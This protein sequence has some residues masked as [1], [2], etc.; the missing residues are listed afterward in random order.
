[1]EITELEQAIEQQEEVLTPLM[2]AKRKLDTQIADV[3]ALIDSLRTQAKE[4]ALQ[5]AL[6][7]SADT[8]Q[9]V[10]ANITSAQEQLSLLRMAHDEV[11]AKIN[12]ETDNLNHLVTTRDRMV[13]ATTIRNLA[14]TRLSHAQ[15]I[16]DTILNLRMLM[17]E[18]ESAGQKIEASIPHPDHQLREK[19]GH[20]KGRNRIL[21][22]IE[23][24][25]EGYPTP[26]PPFMQWE[27][28]AVAPFLSYS[29]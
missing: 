9:A 8:L 18:Y 12:E 5:A 28:D 14:D 11:T 3:N 22:F 16:T 7:A 1:M 21:A 27:R 19:I 20:M 24:V 17:D 29:D 13:R 2:A 10:T 4:A 23:H 6:G 25:V 15:R 26:W